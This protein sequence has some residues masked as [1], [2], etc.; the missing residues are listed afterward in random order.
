MTT[1]YLQQMFGAAHWRVVGLV[2]LVTVVV[3]S[4]A[5]CSTSKSKANHS[6]TSSDV[7]DARYLCP[8][9]TMVFA[10]Y[11]IKE[12]TVDFKLDDASNWITLPIA[13]SGSG[14]RYSD[15]SSELWEHHGKAT[16][17]LP[18]GTALEGCVKQ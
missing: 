3:I 4:I 15:G 7:A 16:V 6:E 11:H 13:M 12:K 8:N 1:P 2:A 9:G 18:D 14:A 10:R 5:A 17:K